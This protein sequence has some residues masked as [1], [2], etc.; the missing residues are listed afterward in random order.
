MQEGNVLL[1]KC[2]KC[3]VEKPATTEFFPKRE[4]GLRAT[5]KICT[6][7]G[8]KNHY[9]NNKERILERNKDYI[10]RNSEKVAEI[11][12]EYYQSNKDAI[13]EW[14]KK[15]NEE[16]KEA[17]LETHKKYRLKNHEFILERD[18][19]Y[20][21]KNKDKILKRHSV[22]LKK[23]TERFRERRTEYERNRR[24]NNPQVRLANALRARLNIAL[25]IIKKAV[26]ESETSFVKIKKADS[27]FNLI[28]CDLYFLKDYLEKQ[29]DENMNW[30]NYGSYWHV[31]HIRPCASFDLTDE[32]QQRI[33]FHYSNLQPLE[34]IENMRKGAKWSS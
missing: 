8:I 33:C 17:I 27:T 12:K 28:G 3:G 23:N 6:K 5:C 1:K 34:A 19:K 31:D 24:K 21:H 4:K 20:Y 30:P 11:R 16:N 26:S 10:K 18:R 22:Y 9:E 13:S 15:Y 2:T 29:F 25:K 32:E 7:A 14:Q